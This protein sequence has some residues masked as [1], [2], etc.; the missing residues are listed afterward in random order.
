MVEFLES[1]VDLEKEEAI[2]IIKSNNLT[3]RIIQ[4]D[5]IPY[6]ITMDVRLDRV[7]IRLEKNKVVT[8]DIG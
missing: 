7:N 5:N 6:M 4:E 3:P 1:L 8:V 2:N